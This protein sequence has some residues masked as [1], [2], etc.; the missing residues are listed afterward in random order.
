MFQDILLAWLSSKLS[1]SLE[2]YNLILSTY[3][4]LLDGA[5]D[6]FSC[7]R[8]TEKW[9]QKFNQAA[10]LDSELHDFKENLDKYN[11]K[12][13]T[14]LD[15]KYPKK[16]SYL[17][18]R[19][20]LVFY[21]QGNLELL[22]LSQMITV[23]GSRNIQNYAKTIM[24]NILIIACQHGIG[25]VSGLAMGVDS[26][27]HQIA[28]QNQSNTIAVIGS[29]L[30]DFSFYPV[31]N[32]ALKNQII[33]NNGLILSEYCLGS[34]ATIYNFPQRNRILAALTEITWVVQA[35]TRSGTLITAAHA[36]DLGKI[37]ATSPASILDSNFSGNLKILKEGANIISDPEDIFQLLGLSTINIS[38]PKDKL[39]LQ[40]TSEF[41]Q[42]LYQSLGQTPVNL[43]ELSI[44]LGTNI[45]SIIS[46]L[47]ILEIN[48]L[49]MNQGLNSWV[50]V[51]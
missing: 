49:A 38:A 32:I 11:V 51:S 31:Q 35:S 36:R 3:G 19:L 7:L 6:G 24:H 23:V 21:Y 42:K 37:V 27:A 22:N 34:K 28:I 30:D 5:L 41:S 44:K 8:A 20:P 12:L 10:D 26:L 9:L 47:S 14:F 39:V 16:L 4:S 13:L 2:R 15:P 43:D 45:Q 25:T 1:L 50:K 48:G 33:Q 40:F 46:E 17:E 18:N 29:G